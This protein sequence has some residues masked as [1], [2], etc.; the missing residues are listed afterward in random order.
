MVVHL[1]SSA[2]VHLT[3][4][5]NM[6]KEFEVSLSSLETGENNFKF[7]F[8]FSIGLFGLSSI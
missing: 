6:G 4:S 2:L 5:V 7:L 8:L 1:T 3:S